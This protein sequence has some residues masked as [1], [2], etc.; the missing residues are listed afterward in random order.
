MPSPKYFNPNLV[1]CIATLF[2]ACIKHQSPSSEPGLREDYK[3]YVPAKIVV[4]PCVFWPNLDA[5]TASFK[6][7]KLCES[8][9]SFILQSFSNQPYMNGFPPST[10]RRI[11]ETEN[12][13]KILDWPTIWREFYI[14]GQEQSQSLM[15][16]YDT[17]IRE[18]KNWLLWL[19]RVSKLTQYTDAVLLPVIETVS[20]S[21]GTDRG[22]HTATRSIVIDLF[23]I[24]SDN[25]RAIWIG[26]RDST[27]TEKS[28]ER[29]ANYPS[30]DMLFSQLFTETL[31]QDYPGRIQNRP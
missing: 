11:A 13:L 21:K 12:D 3:A 7:I 4:F 30:W 15:Q 23:L 29:E 16:F 1:L 2:F 24:D 27:I 19:A 31:W 25:G 28:V 26:K 22:I 10:I 17:G 8:F 9:D 5:A 18:Q 6:D 20:E 14:P